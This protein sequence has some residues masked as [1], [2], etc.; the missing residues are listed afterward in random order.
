M[1]MQFFNSTIAL[2]ASCIVLV[3]KIFILHNKSIFLLNNLE[4]GTKSIYKNA[5]IRYSSHVSIV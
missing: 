4:T 5:D 1:L 2:C 3:S